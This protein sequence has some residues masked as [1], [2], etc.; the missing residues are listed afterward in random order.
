MSPRVRAIAGFKRFTDP[1]LITTGRGVVKEMKDNPNFPNPPEELKTLESAVEEL[2]A[3]LAAQVQGATAATAHK[4][5]KRG[6]VIELLVKL[7][8]YVQDNCGQNPAT[9]LPSGF[10]LATNIVRH[11]SIVYNGNSGAQPNAIEGYS[12]IN[13]GVGRTGWR[14]AVS[15]KRT[16]A[17][18]TNRTHRTPPSRARSCPSSEPCQAIINV[19]WTPIA[20]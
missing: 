7:A 6:A 3:A 8:H 5:N 13:I 11:E 20:S 10:Q 15:V 17:L 19:R 18:D 4:K 2:R 16:A 1:Q 9:L 14:R 12:G